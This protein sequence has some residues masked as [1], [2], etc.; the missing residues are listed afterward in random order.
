MEGKHDP[1]MQHLAGIHFFKRLEPRAR[2][3]FADLVREFIATRHFEAGP[4]MELRNV[5][6]VLVGATAV[7]M[8][9]HI[10]LSAFDAVTH[11]VIH[12]EAVRA[13]DGRL[14]AGRTVGHHSGTVRIELAWDE[15]LRGFM[16][17]RDG[18]DVMV[19]EL[20][21][22]LDLAGG[23]F[24]GTPNLRAHQ[25]YE[26]WSAVLH[27][28]YERMGEPAHPIGDVLRE[29]AATDRAE[30][31]AV[32]SEAY[33]ECPDKLERELPGLFRKLQRFYGP[34]P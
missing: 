7:R 4:D 30:F 5:H 16:N 14:G 11:V 20:A 34:R 10:G 8:V 3:A 22:A 19:H 1:V 21:H 24:D 26:V 33:F 13:S 6:R 17:P 29:Y 9:R 18:V 2:D 32:A 23:A 12:R 15:M 27:N 28:H 31:F 25:D